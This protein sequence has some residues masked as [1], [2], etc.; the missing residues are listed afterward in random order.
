VYAVDNI[1]ANIQDSGHPWDISWHL[2]DDA[3]W[4]PFFGPLL[5]LRELASIQVRS[6]RHCDL[7]GLL[8]R[9]TMSNGLLAALA[10]GCAEAA[11]EGRKPGFPEAAVVVPY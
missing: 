11:P 2:G 8:P 7:G 5:P 9:Q 4:K 6:G 10:T 3:A 1:W